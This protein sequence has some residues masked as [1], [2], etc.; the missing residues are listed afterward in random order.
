M[1]SLVY[2]FRIDEL[3]KGAVSPAMWLGT[4]VGRAAYAATGQAHHE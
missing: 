2:A 4:E 1:P 3:T